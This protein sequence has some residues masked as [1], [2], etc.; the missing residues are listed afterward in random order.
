MFE[1]IINNLPLTLTQFGAFIV[2]ASL[3]EYSHGFIA[4]KL[5]D[6]TAEEAGRL[7]LSPFAH[8]D[9]VGTILMPLIARLSGIP[10]IGWMKP[11]PVNPMNFKNPERGQM[12]TA[13]AGPASNLLLA[14]AAVIF[15]Q[16][17]NAALFPVV[18][19]HIHNASMNGMLSNQTK[20][21]A[22]LY[23]GIL[24]FGIQ[25]FQINLILMAFNILPF[26][27]LDG[28]WILRYILPDRAKE[29]YNKVYP[30]GIII[31]YVLLFFGLLGAWITSILQFSQNILGDIG[32]IN[33]QIF[34]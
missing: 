12:F 10:I 6:K 18:L 4:N 7:T 27:P 5:G 3:H 9:P 1:N 8:I 14:F 29:V 34:N 13:L 15:V 2:A 19:E 26:P 20:A 23:N 33:M 25:F 22:V 21:V 28:G 24:F 30:F 17:I 31:L 11:V 32:L 16:F